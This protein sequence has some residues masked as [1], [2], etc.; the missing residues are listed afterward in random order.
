MATQV[1]RQEP[2]VLAITKNLN[3]RADQFIAASNAC[4]KGI[5]PLASQSAFAGPAADQYR[6]ASNDLENLELKMKR[7]LS[8]RIDEDVTDRNTNANA[9]EEGRSAMRGSSS[10]IGG[11]GLPGIS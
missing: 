1:N 5:E 10:S 7:F 9:Q 4:Q 8:A 3:E 2:E 11:V 6:V